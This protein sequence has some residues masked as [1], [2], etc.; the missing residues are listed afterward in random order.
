[1][2]LVLVPSMQILSKIKS[3]LGLGHSLNLYSLSHQF[4][5]LKCYKIQELPNLNSLEKSKLEKDPGTA[6]IQK[7]KKIERFS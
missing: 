1:M 3:I 4:P 5:F 6:I 7:L 2:V